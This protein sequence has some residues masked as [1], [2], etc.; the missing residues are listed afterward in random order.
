MI[1]NRERERE[2]SGLRGIR[3]FQ[4]VLEKF[5]KPRVGGGYKQKMVEN[6]ALPGLN[7]SVSKTHGSLG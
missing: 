6:V 3:K 5:R 2:R 1:L 7:S 4:P